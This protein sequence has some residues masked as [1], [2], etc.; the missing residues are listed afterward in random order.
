MQEPYKRGKGDKRD[1]EEKDVKIL[2][3]TG[4]SGCKPR[5][6]INCAR[7]RLNPPLEQPRVHSPDEFQ[8]SSFQSCEKTH[9]YCLR[10]AICADF[11][12]QPQEVNTQYSFRSKYFIKVNLPTPKTKVENIQVKK[13]GSDHWN[14]RTLVLI[15]FPT[16][17][18]YL[19][20]NF[21]D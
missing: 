1:T 10:P 11:L 6:A 7:W 4:V 21:T 19:C 5:H 8:N 15:V 18:Y 2:A 13:L 9:S 17:T 14:R 3:E 12:E 20:L 16:L